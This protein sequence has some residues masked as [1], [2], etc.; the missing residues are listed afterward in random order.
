MEASDMHPKPW[1]MIA[2]SLM[3]AAVGLLAA[4][5]APREFL[6]RRKTTPLEKAMWSGVFGRKP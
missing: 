4:V 1:T 6:R 3:A 5:K 2:L